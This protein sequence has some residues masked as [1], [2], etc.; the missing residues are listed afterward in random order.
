MLNIKWQFSTG[1]TAASESTGIRL[2][3]SVDELSKYSSVGWVFS[4]TD[5]T[6]TKEEANT[7]YRVYNSILANGVIKTAADVYNNASY[8][9]YLFVFQITNIPKSSYANN[10]YVR[11]YV[12]LIDGT[13]KY[14]AV[15]TINIKNSLD[16]MASSSSTK[17]SS[18]VSI[19]YNSD[20]SGWSSRWF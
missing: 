16:A 9:K 6:P 15:H 12:V 8:A 19:T 10:I 20:N 4:L 7:S 13:I 14:G 18:T 11:S 1:T 2:I 17:S 5:T 3:A